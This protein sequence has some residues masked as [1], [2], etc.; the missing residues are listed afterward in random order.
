MAGR[1]VVMGWG[2]GELAV[3]GVVGVERRVEGAG[4]KKRSRKRKAADGTGVTA[5]GGGGG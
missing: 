1:A 3:A 2:G 5:E 4:E